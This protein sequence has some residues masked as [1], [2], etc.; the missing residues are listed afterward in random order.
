VYPFLGGFFG[1]WMTYFVWYQLL[2]ASPDF[3]DEITVFYL[4]FW[5]IVNF[6]FVVCLLSLIF[7]LLLK[8]IKSKTPFKR[9][10]N[11]MVVGSGISVFVYVGF[12][13]L[14]RFTIFVVQLF[15]ASIS[16][17]LVRRVLKLTSRT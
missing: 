6:S 1:T 7:Y 4:I 10:L 16:S 11:F 5:W 15:L 3:P 9:S 14:F 8:T 17:F 12:F 2:L 13:Y